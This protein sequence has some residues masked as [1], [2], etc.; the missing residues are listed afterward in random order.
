M[1]RCD[2]SAHFRIHLL[3]LFTIPFAGLNAWA[4]PAP[5]S[6]VL[7]LQPGW[8]TVSIRVDVRNLVGPNSAGKISEDDIRSRVG[9]ANDV[10][11]QCAV[12]FVPRVAENVSAEPL[13]IP[14]KP[15]SQSDLSS[16]AQA[17]NP[18]GFHGAIPLTFAGPWGFFDQSSGLYLIGLGWVFKNAQGIDRIGAMIGAQ[19]IFRPGAG[20]IIAHELGHALSLP[21]TVEINNLMGRNGTRD[22]TM[23]QCNQARSFAETALKDFLL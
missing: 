22:L 10:W 20:P 5:P 9:A 4:A 16:I 21:H 19:H 17:L 14:Y 6:A 18:N 1:L 2:M 13:A 23:D 7:P 3:S 8:S 15:Q 11:S 12:K